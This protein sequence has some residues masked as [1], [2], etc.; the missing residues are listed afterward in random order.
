MMNEETPF[1]KAENIGLKHGFFTR[2]GGISTGIY[3]A[4]NCAWASKD[5]LANVTT[6]RALVVQA[7]GPQ[8]SDLMT[9][10]QVHSNRVQVV[11]R[12]WTRERAPEVDGLVSKQKNVALGVLTADCAPVLFSDDKNQV[13]GAA[14]AGW[15]GAFGGVLENTVKA[16]EGLGADRRCITA[17]IG[18]CIQQSSYEV[19][20]GFRKTFLNQDPSYADYFVQSKN[21]GH[22]QFDLPGFVKMKL[23]A[24]GLGSIENLAVDTY[25]AKKQFFSYRRTT[26]LGEP[27]YGRQ[28]SVI[29]LDGE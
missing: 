12:I 14:H 26:H 1:L 28:I 25:A 24:L 16:M 3:D 8:V 18:P 6:N 27:D 9:A 5:D 23:A 4:L 11:D 13:I 29:V 10:S 21:K 17:A 20:G 7:M 22:F 2:C 19:D 15:K